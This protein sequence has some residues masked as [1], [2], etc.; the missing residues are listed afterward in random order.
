MIKGHCV[1]VFN[2]DGGE[3]ITQLPNGIDVSDSGDVLVGDSN[4]ERFHMAVFTR[5]G[6]FGCE[7]VKLL[8]DLR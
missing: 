6:E 8:G 5:E 3:H 2:K 4:G 7:G 1:V